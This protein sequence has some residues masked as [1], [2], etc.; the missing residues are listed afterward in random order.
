MLPI[1]ISHYSKSTELKHLTNLG[2]MWQ[3]YLSLATF[4]Y[5]TFNTLNLANLSLYEL[6]FRRKPT[7]LLNLE[8]TPD[9][10]VAGTFQDYHVVLNKRLKYLHKLLHDFK[11]KRLTLINKDRAFFQ[12]NNGDLVYILTPLIS[13]L[14]TASRKVMIKYAVLCRFLI[15]L[16]L[17]VHKYFLSGTELWL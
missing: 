15:L 12:Y 13:Q 5:N 8:T 17:E 16:S 4:A 10:K 2:Q 7:I 14:H 3:K 9:I 1:I 11:L 6:V